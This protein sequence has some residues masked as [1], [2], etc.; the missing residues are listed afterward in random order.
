MLR[1]IWK[2]P[3]I[4]EPQIT[5]MQVG[6]EIFSVGHKDG[7]LVLW[8]YV[9]PLSSEVENRRFEVYRTGQPFKDANQ[10][11]L[12]LGTVIIPSNYKPARSL[13]P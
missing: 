5:S 9:D 3:L 7:Q 4:A 11:S 12:F 6:A 8:A 13:A 2:Y 1:T 10:V